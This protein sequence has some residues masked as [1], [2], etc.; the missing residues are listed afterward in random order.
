M[1]NVHYLVDFVRESGR[2]P[3]D[4]VL[5]IWEEYMAFHD[6][7]EA[8]TRQ[9]EMHA[10]HYSHLDPEEARFVTPEMIRNFCIAGHPE[11]IVDQLRTLE[12]QGLNG[13]VFNMPFETMYRKIEDFSREII[14]RM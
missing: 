14:S 3:P 4:Y 6:S 12:A 1:A 13:I 11:E 7:R 9:Q 10:S 8:D 2:E 5:P